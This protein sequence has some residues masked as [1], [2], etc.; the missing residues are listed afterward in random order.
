MGPVG[1]CG[2]RS[3]C[4]KTGGEGGV[5]ADGAPPPL[6]CEGSGNGGKGGRVSAME[7]LSSH[8]SSEIRGKTRSLAAVKSVTVP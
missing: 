3:A 2:A 7:P 1:I 5:F 4:V 6:C 8:N